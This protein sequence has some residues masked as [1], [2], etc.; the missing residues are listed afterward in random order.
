MHLLQDFRHA[1]RLFRRSPG[2]TATAVLVLALGIGANTAA[3]SLVNALLLQPRLGR[4][5]SVVAVFNRDTI[6]PDSYR[7]FSYP[8]YL[9]LRDRGDVFE[10]VM[11]HTFAMVGVRE[12]DTTRRSFVT[13]VSAN[14]FSTLGI[15]LAAGRT[16]TAQE[17]RPGVGIPVAIASYSVWRRSG[18]D[19]AFIGKTVR[20]N[21]TDVTIVGVAPKGFGGTMT[22]LSLDWF[23]PLGLYDSLVND[24]FKPR[25][26]GLA[27]RGN[28]AL[29]LAGAL[30]PGLASD[31]VGRRL[32]TIA[33]QLG[34]EFP[35]TDRD[36]QFIVSRL[37]RTGVSS[38]PDD[39]SQMTLIST[40]LTSM[41][42]LVL[43]V[44]CLNLANLLLARGATRRR[45][46]AIRQALGS[47]RLRIV[48]QLLLEGA[49]LSAAGAAI[50][51]ALA[52]W[53]TGVV[54]AGIARALPIEVLVEPSMRIL[55]AAIVFAVLSTLLFA[56]G[57]A[58][59]L[60]RP[61][62]SSDLRA[63]MQ[64]ETR[65]HR[66]GPALIAAQ[67]AV[68]LGLVVA[69]GLFVRGAIKAASADPGFSLDRQLVFSVDPS[70]IGYDEPRTRDV[71]ARALDRLQQLPGVE[72]AALASIV[73]FG[74]LSEN[75]YV[76]VPGE[77][78]RQRPQF[79]IVTAGYFEA[80]RLPILRGRGFTRA[81]DEPSSRRPT[82]AIV[83]V[84]LSRRMFG[85][86]DPLGRRI[87][88]AVKEEAPPIDFDIVGIVPTTRHDL[89][90]SDPAG[91]V[92]SPFGAQFRATMTLH[93]RR[94]P[95]ATDA[96]A[97][98]AVQNELR[99]VDSRLPVLT[100]R[101]M[102]AHRDMSISEW[103]V[104]TAATLFSTMGILALIIAAIGVYGV[105][106]FDVSKRRREIGIR[107][108]LGATARNVIALILRDGARTVLI[109]LGAGVALAAGIGRLVSG[110]LYQVN[111]FDPVV[112][113]S[114]AA[115]LGGA[116]LLASY[117]PAR[118]ATRIEPLGALRAD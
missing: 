106:A 92:Y 76:N 72:A 110:F 30:K 37:P 96:T 11:A 2:F 104:R 36:R 102:A 12:G 40:L 100:A 32:E 8:E 87:Q 109:G 24:M 53:T 114:A 86:G 13:L 52:W 31:A 49:M 95:G 81:D 57:P 9:D 38:E 29:N 69:G 113:I 27:D 62:M 88:I 70:M 64:A 7:D 15:S 78:K 115:I 59:A 105:K 35:G 94:A 22:L 89:F 68:S 103:S 71:F 50:G 83:D 10:S 73:S 23:F 51:A 34:H 80:L 43:V 5:D 55:S 20:I 85:D 56:L 91:H 17:E 66:T 16:F 77:T 26:T 117:L 75:R 39:E 108:A 84:A 79:L 98:S 42:G 3:F 63:Q 99:R 61:T 90:E 54:T 1:F 25:T 60:S 97:L 44:A 65:R 33:T 111:P 28:Y 45:E 47:G 41:A 67:L 14:Y 112:L 46:I 93:V 74:E 116:A 18:F 19:P 82:P 6:K 4:I 48:K 107:I 58:W 118:R 101:T 21:A